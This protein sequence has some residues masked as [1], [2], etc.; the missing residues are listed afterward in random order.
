MAAAAAPTALA[1]DLL[2]GCL[3]G[4]TRYRVRA[5]C[6]V[7]QPPVFCHCGACRRASG[8]TGGVAWFSVPAAALA[9]TSEARRAAFRSSAAAER[10]F[11]GGCGSPLAFA[12]DGA[13]TVDVATASLDECAGDLPGA[14]LP[15]AD[16]H[17]EGAPTWERAQRAAAAAA[18]P[19]PASEETAAAAAA[20]AA[21]ADGAAAQP[22]AAGPPAAPTDED[23][24][25]VAVAAARTAGAIMRRTMGAAPAE[26]GGKSDLVTASDL[27]CQAAIAAAVRAAFPSH[28]LLGEE[29]VPAGAAAAAAAIARVAEAPFLWIVDPID[30]TTNFAASLPLCCVSIACARA[31]RVA[32]AAIYDPARDEMFTAMRGRGARLNGSTPLRA[33]AA[34]ELRDAIIGFGGLGRNAAVAGATHRGLGLLGGRVR[35]LRGLGSAALH[36]AYVA[37]GR[38]DAS[39]DMSLSVWDSAAGSLLVTEAGGAVTSFAG[40]AFGLTTRDTL[41]SNGAI[42]EALRA[43]L[44]E[45]GAMPP[46]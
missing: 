8:A 46:A 38:L 28:A 44:L 35:A 13:A 22:A 19:A 34:R 27:E 25:A 12:R 11:C 39:L 17:R 33:G 31:G 1:V 14:V 37:A 40:G 21:A 42:H 32:V 5:P 15:R 6:A 26:K 45:A 29:D 30:G 7:E 43:A 20:A 23:L 4:A 18:L 10:T 16:E 24:L 36:L 3:C 2:G 9:W 41:A